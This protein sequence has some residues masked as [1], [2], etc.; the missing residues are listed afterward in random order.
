MTANSPLLVRTPHQFLGESPLGFVLRASEM[1]GYET[2]RHLFS[3][4][5]ANR[6]QMFSIGLEM[7][8]IAEV[9]GRNPDTLRG[10]REPGETDISRVNVCGHPLVTRDLNLAMPKICPECIQEC[11]F[12]PAWTD[13]GLVDACPNHGRMLLTR[14]PR[15][16]NRLSWFRPGVLRC[17]CGANLADA[18]GAPIGVEHAALLSQVVAKVMHV[19]VANPC[20]MPVE[21]FKGMTLH[22]LLVITQGLVQFDRAAQAQLS[23]PVAASGGWLFSNWPENLFTVLRKLF[24]RDAADKNGI[25]V[26]RQHFERIYRTIRN[27]LT[28]AEDIHFLMEI[29]SEYSCT[30]KDG[31]NSQTN[32]TR[33]SP[34]SHGAGSLPVSSQIAKSS[35][36]ENAKNVDE[37]SIQWNN[38]KKRRRVTIAPVGERS[39]SIRNAA[40]QVGLPVTVLQSLRRSGHFEARHKASRAVTFH[41]ADILAFA[42]KVSAIPI[43][44]PVTG[45][46]A[47]SLEEALNLKL[48]FNDG[49]GKLVAAVFDGKLSVIGSVKP[50]LLGLLLDMNEIQQFIAELRASAFGGGATPS[51]VA[52][53]LHCDPLVVP[54]LLASGYLE[55]RRF[56]AGLRITRE[57][58]NSFGAT[59]RSVAGMAKDLR[60]SSRC[61]IRQ[62]QAAGI[63]VLRFER[64]YGKGPQP[65]V[66]IADCDNFG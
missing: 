54:V 51:E 36:L 10:Y 32:R 31:G 56:D 47:L 61:L 57:S 11:G 12:I 30:L 16:G 37:S 18:R 55:G 1:N 46:A 23:L 7:N 21:Q 41:E 26:V 45:T 62:L 58:V 63:D 49:K 39:F 24:P 59:F 52:K 66:R 65:F 28:A 4:A 43:P 60:T 42:S 53:M 48:K 33:T 3:M 38:P 34:L 22:G 44:Q 64:G 5:K 20:A 25:I 9:L 17:G 6:D 2:P 35:G 8:K 40:K 27:K 15:C 29:I 13:L 14:C 50:G 19:A